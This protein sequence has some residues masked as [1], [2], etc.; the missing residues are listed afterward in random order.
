MDALFL[1]CLWFYH[2]V[3]YTVISF[4]KISEDT[5]IFQYFFCFCTGCFIFSSGVPLHLLYEG[6]GQNKVVSSD[7][8]VS[9]HERP[10][11]TSRDQ[12]VSQHD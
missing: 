5:G 10:E 6:K 1:L 9:R 7:E 3:F 8:E 4:I 11:V 2:E 12:E